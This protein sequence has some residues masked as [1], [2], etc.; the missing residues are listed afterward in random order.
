MLTDYGFFVIET[1]T[2]GCL[3][4]EGCHVSARTMIAIA[5]RPTPMNAIHEPQDSR[6]TDRFTPCNMDGTD[7]ADALALAAVSFRIWVA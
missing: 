7:T 6:L 1:L 3:S 4:A 2:M 5:P